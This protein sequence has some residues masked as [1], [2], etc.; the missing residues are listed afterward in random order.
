MPD[1]MTKVVFTRKAVSD[2]NEIW[3]YTFSTWSKEQANIYY[4]TLLADCGKVAE[5]PD[6]LGRNFDHVKTS[7]KGYQSGK[8]IIFYRKLKDGRV[9]VIRI[10][11]EKMDFQRHL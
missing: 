10:L 5:K 7:L 4:N 1:T 2:L 3:E 11:H 9:R 8:H 6:S